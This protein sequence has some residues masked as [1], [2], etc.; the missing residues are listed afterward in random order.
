MS[1]N[2]QTRFT[3]PNDPEKGGTAATAAE[4]CD[5]AVNANDSPENSGSGADCGAA[6]LKNAC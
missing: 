6:S 1:H 2:P 5:S 3:S 4:L